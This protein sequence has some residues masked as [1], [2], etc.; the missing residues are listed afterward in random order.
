MHEPLRGKTHALLVMGYWIQVGFQLA[1]R[2][3][4]LPLQL[5]EA[6]LLILLE[7]PHSEQGLTELFL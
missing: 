2:Q 4:Q 7:L 1:A 5:A 6:P 3:T